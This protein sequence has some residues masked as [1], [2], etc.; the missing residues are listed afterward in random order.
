MDKS[1]HQQQQVNR[2]YRT[3]T[4]EI[5]LYR[6]FLN[7]LQFGSNFVFV[8]HHLLTK[9]KRRAQPPKPLE[10]RQSLYF[11]ATCQAQGLWGTPTGY[12][13]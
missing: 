6:Q 12:Q 4:P 1:A 11:H 7:C 5:E 3:A 2:S 8:V 13:T 9:G 10:A